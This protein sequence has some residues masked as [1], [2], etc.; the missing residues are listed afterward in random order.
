MAYEPE[1]KDPLCR[2]C[3]ALAVGD[4]FLV[5]GKAS[6]QEHLVKFAWRPQGPHC[7][8]PGIIVVDVICLQFTASERHGTSYGDSIT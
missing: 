3:A 1:D 4:H 7:A 5:R 2:A 6:P 8:L